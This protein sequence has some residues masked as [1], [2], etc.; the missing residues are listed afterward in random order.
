MFYYPTPKDYKSFCEWRQQSGSK[1][2]LER[3]R[4]YFGGGVTFN[5]L[6]SS[7]LARFVTPTLQ[8]ILFGIFNFLSIF[9]SSSL[10]SQLPLLHNYIGKL[11][12][13]TCWKNLIIDQRNLTV[14]EQGVS[15]S[16]VCYPIKHNSDFCF[17]CESIFS[18]VWNVQSVRIKFNSS[19]KNSIKTWHSQHRS[20]RMSVSA[21]GAMG[22]HRGQWLPQ[23]IP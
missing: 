16:H 8:Q 13:G 12:K 18:Q 9:A 3:Q 4:T 5:L 21:T 7:A 6:I 14:K 20:L 17:G 2:I 19:R 22:C 1:A 15:Y 11:Y 23:K 10:H